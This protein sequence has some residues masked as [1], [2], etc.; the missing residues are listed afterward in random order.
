M[1][2]D[3]AKFTNFY[4]WFKVN[5]GFDS[6][7]PDQV[8]VE[9][10]DF[11]APQLVTGFIDELKAKKIDFSINGEDRLYRSHGQTMPEISDIRMGKFG[12][13]PDVVVW[14]HSHDE[15]V[16][17]VQLANVFDVIL[18]PFGGGTSVSGGVKCPDDERS[19]VSVDTSQ[20]NRMLWLNK[21]TLV[22]CFE[23]GVVGKSLEQC[24]AQEG[25]TMGHEPDSID[26]STLGGWVATRASGMK[27]N[28]YGNIEDIVLSMKMVTSRGVL[29]REMIAPRTSCGPDFNQ[30]IL[31]SEGTLGVITEVTFKVHPLPEVC[32]YDALI[33]PDFHRGVSCLREIAMRQ[34]QPASIRLVDNLQFHLS[35]TLKPDSGWLS[36]VVAS[37]KMF[38]LS[39]VKGYDLTTLCAATVLFEGNEEE[40]A[41]QEKLVYSI[42]Q[43]HSGFSA[44]STN[45]KNGFVS[46]SYDFWKFDF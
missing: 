28:K 14:P 12:R 3:G 27:K 19:I 39:N 33:F 24:L 22:A 2:E 21:E 42:A 10:K 38:A 29:E 30:V 4:D 43:R 11:P 36:K 44:G 5:Y 20:M 16:K 25:F 40:V 41:L 6:K 17:I 7:K 34:C 15:V 1:F 45:G 32:K 23:A 37:L 9:I 35:Q 31:G 26:F 46:D 13:I 18:I 8:P